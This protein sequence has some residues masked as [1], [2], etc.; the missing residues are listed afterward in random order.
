MI[1]KYEVETSRKLH[2]YTIHL[3]MVVDKPRKQFSENN[4]DFLTFRR[5]SMNMWWMKR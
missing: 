2:S 4:R 1:I 3:F 5:K